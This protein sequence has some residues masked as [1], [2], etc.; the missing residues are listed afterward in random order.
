MT[1]PDHHTTIAL[2][3]KPVLEAKKDVENASLLIKA[4]RLV[5]ATSNNTAATPS[6]LQARVVGGRPLPRVELVAVGRKKRANRRRKFSAM[7]AL[8]LGIKDGPHNEGMP[9]DV[10]RVVMG[11]VMPSWD[12]LRRGPDIC[13]PLQG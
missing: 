4:R 12:P 10:F 2:L 1:H 11:F 9:R 13:P 6:Y 8:F 7:L 3:L 5:V